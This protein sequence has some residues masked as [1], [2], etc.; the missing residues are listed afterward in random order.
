MTAGPWVI[1]IPSNGDWLT[2]NNVS[3]ER[4][5]QSRRV[6]A[7]RKNAFEASFYTRPKLPKGIE[8]VRLDIHFRWA[9]S[10]VA[11][12]A[13]MDPTV[14][15]IVDGAIGRPLGKSPG[16]GLIVSDSDRH[17][18]YGPRTSEIAVFPRGRVAQDPYA[19]EVVLTITDLTGESS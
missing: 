13:N 7:W 14:K 11:E 15:V 17:L 2:S 3:R 18:V 4:M 10:P 8:R 12:V 6:K 19:G 5:A 16:Y 9:K 1:R